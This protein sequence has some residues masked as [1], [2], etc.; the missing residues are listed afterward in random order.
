[1][2]VTGSE[3]VGLIPLEAIRRAGI[4]YLE[5]QGAS[6]GVPESYLV[7]T[8]VQSLGL[9][10]LGG[11]DPMQKIIEYRVAGDSPL[12]SSTLREFVDLTSTDSPAPGGGSVA[13]LCG[14]LAASLTAMVA[15]LTFGKK[16]Y[17][18]VSAEM[19]ALA[20]EAQSLKDEFLRAVDEDARAFGA[21]MAA[22]RLPKGTR[23]EQ[24]RREEVLQEATKRAIEVPLSVMRRCATLLPLVERVAEKGNRASISDAGVAA[25]ALKTAAGGAY[26]NVLINLGGLSDR[27][28]AETARDEAQSLLDRITEATS[29]VSGNIEKALGT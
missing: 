29:R 8:A 16:G 26:L 22:Q 18:A 27:R 17:E 24:A 13:A 15:N 9:R 2:L 19:S 23:E 7:E 21:V 6:A 12:A 3:L 1:L 20:V 5:K 28:S 4:F 10:E 14:S 25:M 11:F